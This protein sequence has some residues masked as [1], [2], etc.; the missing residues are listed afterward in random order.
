MTEP[1]FILTDPGRNSTACVG[2]SAS[3][4]GWIMNRWPRRLLGGIVV[5]LLLIGAPGALQAQQDDVKELVVGPAWGRP[6]SP[7]TPPR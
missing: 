7:T 3:R 2:R 5:T 6:G 1:R 4:G